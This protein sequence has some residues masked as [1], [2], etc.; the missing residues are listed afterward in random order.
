MTGQRVP[1][2]HLWVDGEPVDAGV[3]A[4]L[5][6]E[7][8]V[9][10]ASTFAFTIPSSPVAAVAAGDAGGDWDTLLRGQ[11]AT[12]LGMPGARLLSRV[13][14]GFSLVPPD[15]SDGGTELRVVLDGYATALEHRYAHARVPDSEL[16]VTGVDA[17][18]LMHLQT[19]TRRWQDRSD[20]QV[21]REIFE[22]YGFGAQVE[23]TPR[24]DGTDVS[25]LQRCTDAEFLRLLARRH[26]FEVFVAPTADEVTPGRHPGTAVT[27]RFRAAPVGRETLPQA[28]LFPHDAPTIVDMTARYDAHQPT[29]VRSWHVDDRRRTLRSV[30]VT[31]PGYPRTGER[32]RAD[33]LQGALGEILGDGRAPVAVEVRSADVPSDDDEL[34]RLA[35]ADLRGADWFA[36]AE[37]TLAAGRYP[38]FVGSGRMLPVTGTGPVFAGDWYVRA[39]THRWGAAR[40]PLGDPPAVGAADGESEMVYEVDVELVRGALGGEL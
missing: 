31:E 14:I 3:V 33:V 34:A 25:L 40:T 4:S 8:R 28:D 37:A 10:R 12:D 13:T 29:A 22:R 9:D 15:A 21:A 6:V 32:S 16:V 27:G 20:A 5:T 38:G 24:R 1:H 11:P 18:C 26:G 2:L 17:S 23:D 35:R 30:E 7:D 36:T 39:A 19:V